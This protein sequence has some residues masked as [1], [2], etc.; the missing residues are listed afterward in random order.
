MFAKI[1]EGCSYGRYV[2]KLECAN[3]MTRA[4]SDNLHKLATNTQ[5]PLE[6]RKLLLGAAKGGNI[7]RLERIVKGVRTSIKQAG[8][9]FNSQLLCFVLVI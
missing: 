1:Q 4:L 9:V 7:S 3:H 6:S 2:C 8:E 5:Y